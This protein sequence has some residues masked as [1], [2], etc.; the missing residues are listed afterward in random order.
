M[1]LSRTVSKDK[2][3]F[4]SKIVKMAM[5]MLGTAWP[6]SGGCKVITY[7][8]SLQTASFLLAVQLSSDHDDD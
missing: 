4:Q 8:E 1:S 7:V 6:V 5:R 2:R 3:R